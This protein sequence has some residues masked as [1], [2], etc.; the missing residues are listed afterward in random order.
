MNGVKEMEKKIN[1]MLFEFEEINSI[2]KKYINNLESGDD[3]E[4]APQNKCTTV[5]PNHLQP[6]LR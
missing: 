5:V 1:A 2:I 6:I 4:I 3:N